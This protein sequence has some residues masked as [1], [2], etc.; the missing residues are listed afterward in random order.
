MDN[1]DMCLY[2]SPDASIIETSSV[3]DEGFFF[4]FGKISSFAKSINKNIESVT[5][6]I[7][8]SAKAFMNELVEMEQEAAMV[9]MSEEQDEYSNVVNDSSTSKDANGF[10][11]KLPFPWEVDSISPTEQEELKG[12]V[13]NLSKNEHLLLQPC[14]SDSA[15]DLNFRLDEAHIELIDCLMK[16]DPNLS[17][18]FSKISGTLR[19]VDVIMLVIS[20]LSFYH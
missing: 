9:S 1:S 18:V 10:I 15:S 16:L 3:E 8:S 2:S 5:H 20:F 11:R 13:F 12:H 7:N 14:E 6:S 17:K 4:S 19:K